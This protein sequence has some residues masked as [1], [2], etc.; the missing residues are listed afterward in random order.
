ME[1]LEHTEKIADLFKAK[2]KHDRPY[3]VSRY[4]KNTVYYVF[5]N[6]YQNS[7]N[8]DY[9]LYAKEL[10]EKISTI[11]HTKGPILC[12]VHQ[13]SGPQIAPKLLHGRPIED[14]HPLLDREEFNSNMIV[15]PVGNE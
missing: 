8:A 6:D 5:K 12:N 15:E 13:M 11:F 7:N 1:K 10:Y 3:L 9:L 2:G 14:S 4:K